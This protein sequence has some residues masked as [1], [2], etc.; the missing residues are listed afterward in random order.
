MDRNQKREVTIELS[1]E[2]FFQTGIKSDICQVWTAQLLLFVHCRCVSLFYS[3][4]SHYCVNN[5]YCVLYQHALLLPV[6]I[7][8]LRFHKSLEVLEGR[9]RYTFK[10]RNLLQV[11]VVC[12]EFLLVVLN[13]VHCYT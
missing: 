9:M 11:R 13:C 4:C 12:V 3:V 6:L 1:A 10:D 8:H 5:V 2:G 7:A